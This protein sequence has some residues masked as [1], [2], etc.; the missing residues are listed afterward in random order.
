MEHPLKAAQ[1]ATLPAQIATKAPHLVVLARMDSAAAAAGAK[2]S[3]QP[4]RRLGFWFSPIYLD[5][6]GHL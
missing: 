1:T 6:R 4:E 3:I 2:H 5:A